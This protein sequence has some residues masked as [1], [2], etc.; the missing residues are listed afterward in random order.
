VAGVDGGIPPLDTTLATL[1]DLFGYMNA[2]VRGGEG[3]PVSQDLRDQ[4]NEVA[5]RLEVEAA[6]KPP[7]LNSMLQ[8]LAR[9]STDSIRSLRDRL[10]TLWRS[11]QVAPY[12]DNNLS[13]RYPLARSFI[14]M[15]G[16]APGVRPSTNAIQWSGGGQAPSLT[17]EA[18]NLAAPKDIDLNAFGR[19]FGPNGLMDDFFQKHLRP[20]V[21]TSQTTWAW[22]GPGGPEDAVAPD[23]LLAFQRAAEVKQA[24]FSGD[25]QQP[26]IRFELLPRDMGRAVVRAALTIDGQQ[27]NYQINQSGAVT[28]LR[29]PG[30]NP[31]QVRLKLEPTLPGSRS[32]IS[33]SGSW[34]WLRLLDRA[35]LRSTSQPGNFEVT[36]RVGNRQAVYEMRVNSALNPFRLNALEGFRC[37]QQL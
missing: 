35:Q 6:R 20:Y 27:V 19:F 36:F 17:S 2:I 18:A 12:F 37:P 7:P 15:A 16:Q 14:E 21:D 10:N 22:R 29:W 34:A 31:G 8:K 9:D 23:A 30:P 28:P 4:V 3:G 5:N 33:E 13:G 24:M 11:A 26:A 25:S 1:G 32:E